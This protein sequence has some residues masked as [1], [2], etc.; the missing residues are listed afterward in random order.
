MLIKWSCDIL[1]TA[2]VLSKKSFFFLLFIKRF[3]FLPELN[4][5][6]TLN[7]DKMSSI[8]D[9]KYINHKGKNQDQ[10]LMQKA[11]F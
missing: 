10:D 8:Q 6:I 11:S 9:K 1:E 5:N 2:Y 7:F 4:C 3:L